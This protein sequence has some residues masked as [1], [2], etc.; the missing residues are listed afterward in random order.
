M[1][2]WAR[3]CEVIRWL[4]WR[5]VR[6]EWPVMRPLCYFSLGGEDPRAGSSEDVCLGMI[7]SGS[8]SNVVWVEWRFKVGNSSWWDGG[9]TIGTM[10][11][12]DCNVTIWAGEDSMCRDVVDIFGVGITSNKGA[13]S[14]TFLIKDAAIHQRE[15]CAMFGCMKGINMFLVGDG[16]VPNIDRAKSDLGPHSFEWGW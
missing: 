10:L 4:C 16:C 13:W 9:G 11:G 8:D 7:G 6:D 2:M 12:Y 1:L 14:K 5:N 15:I 3:W